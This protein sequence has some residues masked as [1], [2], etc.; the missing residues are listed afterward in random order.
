MK[1][2]KLAASVAILMAF[3]GNAFSADVTLKMGN[4]GS[5][6]GELEIRLF[7]EARADVFPLGDA[8]LVERIPAKT[9]E[10]VHVFKD[11]PAGKYAI[12]VYQDLD[13]NG[14]IK[15]N[16]IGAPQEPVAN[17]GKKAFLKPAFEPSSFQV[18]DANLEVTANF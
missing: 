6:E 18:V 4:V 10:V 7:D 13:N 2:K 12:G 8:L 3:A 17:T 5:T 11:L 16:V 1:V 14:E 9:G 15:T